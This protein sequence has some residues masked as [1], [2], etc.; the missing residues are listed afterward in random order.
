M[1][2]I[3]LTILLL[4]ACH[5]WGTGDNYAATYAGFL[6]KSAVCHD[7]DRDTVKDYAWCIAGSDRWFCAADSPNAGECWPLGSGIEFTVRR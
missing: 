1:R 2:N 5:D 4:G 3:F 6:D 7:L